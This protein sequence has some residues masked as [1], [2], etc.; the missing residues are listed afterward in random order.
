MS[1]FLRN[2]RIGRWGQE[3]QEVIGRCYTVETVGRTS[4]NIK[5][6]YSGSISQKDQQNIS[7]KLGPT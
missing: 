4:F 2:S 1:D 6:G 5:P 3:I 7:Q